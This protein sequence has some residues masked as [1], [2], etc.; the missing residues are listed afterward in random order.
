MALP[1]TLTAPMTWPPL[2]LSSCTAISVSLVSPDCETATYSV[3]GSTTGLRYRNSLAGSASA[4]M[5]A[6]SST[7]F[8][9]ICP[10]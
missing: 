4:G 9:P 8:A 6:S 1:T 2:R 5:R 7:R 10:A 3:S